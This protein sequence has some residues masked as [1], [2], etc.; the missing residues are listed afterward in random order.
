MKKY[1][2]HS[3]ANE[4]RCNRF[5]S[6]FHAPCAQATAHLL[7]DFFEAPLVLWAGSPGEVSG[8]EW[9]ALNSSSN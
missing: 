3:L 9:F 1:L 7:A 5:G 6:L 8:L 2:S 4:H